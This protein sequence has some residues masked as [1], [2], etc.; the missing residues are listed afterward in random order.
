M[1]NGGFVE[2]AESRQVVFTLQE[3]RVARRWE[4][5]GRRHGEVHLLSVGMEVRSFWEVELFIF[6]SYGHLSI[7]ELQLELLIPK[8]V[9]LKDH[10]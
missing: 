1:E 6:F 3:I 7:R 4:V 8:T 5:R 10:G 9:A 2:E